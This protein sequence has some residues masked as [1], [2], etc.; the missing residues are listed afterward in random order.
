MC[1]C[2]WGW[3]GGV[4]ILSDLPIPMPGL[5]LPWF[6]E[7]VSL[8]HDFFPTSLL[9]SKHIALKMILIFFFGKFCEL[10]LDIHCNSKL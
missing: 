6:C 8:T 9:L 1:V 10:L 5:E 3:G 4:P 7:K 2:W